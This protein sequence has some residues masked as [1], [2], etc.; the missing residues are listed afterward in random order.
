MEKYKCIVC[1]DMPFNEQSD[2]C[3][4]ECI[5]KHEERERIKSLLKKHWNISHPNYP[6]KLEYLFALID[7]RQIE[8]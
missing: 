1:G 6:N 8:E 7:C 5:E 2:F 4:K 3:S